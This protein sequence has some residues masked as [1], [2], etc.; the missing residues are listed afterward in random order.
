MCF[1]SEIGCYYVNDQSSILRPGSCTKIVEKKK[2]HE[3]FCT[4]FNF[5]VA[6]FA[7]YVRPLEA[8][9]GTAPM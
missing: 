2:F 8:S 9:F 1:E 6:Q 4:I 5:F 7:W 3:G